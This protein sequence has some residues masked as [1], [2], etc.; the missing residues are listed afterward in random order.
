[1]LTEHCSECGASIIGTKPS[2]GCTPNGDLLNT[3][4][5]HRCGCPRTRG[6]NLSTSATIDAKEVALQNFLVSAVLHRYFFIEGFTER[7]DLD[8][9]LWLREN[10]QWEGARIAP[11]NCAL[12]EAHA[13]SIIARQMLRYARTSD[14]AFGN[15]SPY[16]LD[17]KT[18]SSYQTNET[19]SAKR[20]PE[21]RNSDDCRDRGSSV[22]CP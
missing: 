4:H 10:Y 13:M 15:H 5:C 18:I 9:L 6:A 12:A 11:T 7:F 19:D 1:M 3:S 2:L 8:L 16:Q 22:R 20:S 17:P 14:R 21:S